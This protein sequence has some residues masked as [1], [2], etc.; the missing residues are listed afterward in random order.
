MKDAARSAD[1]IAVHFEV[2]GE[3]PR[4]LVLVHGWSCDRSYWDGQLKSFAHRYRVVAV[5]L[6]G[7]GES[8]AGR[9]E[10][11]MPAFGGDVA[12][13]LE[14]LE[15]DDA[16]LVGH[17]MGGDVIVETA[18]RAPERVRGLVWVDTY[19]TLGDPRSRGE[20]EAFVDRFRDDFATTTREFVRGMFPS[21]ADPDLVERVVADMSA[22]PPEVALGALKHA[23]SNDGPVLDG[24]RELA[25]PVVAINP[26]HRPTD[27]E[28][29]RR[30][31][32]TTVLVPGVGH[33]PML[34]E[35]EAFDRLLEE[36][37]DG[38]A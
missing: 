29:L 8:G 26:D 27:V 16:V 20:L 33:F 5:D 6:P 37:L 22:A 24:L 3:G 25:V 32:V 21:G 28:A 11:T 4:A 19:S 38:F 1:G 34:E 36:V 2:R 9:R 13:V 15:L 10:W 14:K 23:F 30:H 35:P 12:A 18:L 17:S 31:G 7:H